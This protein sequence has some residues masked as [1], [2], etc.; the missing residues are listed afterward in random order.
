MEDMFQ[1][2]NDMEAFHQAF[3]VKIESDQLRF[4]PT[5]SAD[6]I[7]I[8][9]MTNAL[10]RF[11]DAIVFFRR[12]A[13]G[14]VA[15]LMVLK[16]NRIIDNNQYVYSVGYSVNKEFRGQGLAKNIIERTKVHARGFFDNFGPHYDL[17][18]DQSYRYF[19]ESVVAQGNESSIRLASTLLH[20][21]GP[22]S[23]GKEGR[24][25]ELSDVYRLTL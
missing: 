24:T 6:D 5:P 16:K 22:V 1:D 8:V 12:S 9:C 10:Q 19:L 4:S 20:S 25:D 17:G 18:P 13:S 7:F 23:T 2:L 11:F 15:A 21:G 3:Q 14:S